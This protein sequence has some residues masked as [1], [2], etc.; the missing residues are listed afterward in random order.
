MRSSSRVGGNLSVASFRCICGVCLVVGEHDAALPRGVIAPS[1]GVV[2][3]AKPV[4][5]SVEEPLEHHWVRHAEEVPLRV[6]VRSGGWQ[7]AG[8]AVVRLVVGGGGEVPSR[9]GVAAGTA[10]A[11]CHIGVG[12][13]SVRHRGAVQAEGESRPG[14]RTSPHWSGCRLVSDRVALRGEARCPSSFR[15]RLS[16]ALTRASTASRC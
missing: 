10:L 3:A 9:R 15:P 2:G 1:A 6:P 7:F 14:N 4:V 8:G 13:R 5:R 11:R 16:G 12:G